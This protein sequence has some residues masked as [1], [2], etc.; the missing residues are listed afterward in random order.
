VGPH[1]PLDAQ[2]A[3]G[4]FLRDALENR[5]IAISGDGTAQ[6]SYLYASDLAIALWTIL[7][8]GAPARTYNVGSEEAVSLRNV[9]AKIAA[10]QQPPLPVNVARSPIRGAPVQRYIPSIARLERELGF[11]QRVQLDEAIA[12]TLAWHRSQAEDLRKS[13]GNS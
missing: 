8:R 12:R 2:F 7:F 4:N 3:V 6:R 13:A 10:S 11:T 5:A 9:A 1:L